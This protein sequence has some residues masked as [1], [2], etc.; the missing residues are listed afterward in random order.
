M[1]PSALF[2]FTSVTR[3]IDK[4]V[5][6]GDRTWKKHW[7]ISAAPS[8]PE[9]FAS[10]PITYERAFG[11]PGDSRNPVG[12]GPKTAAVARFEVAAQSMFE[13]LGSLTQRVR[14]S[15]NMW[16]GRASVKIEKHTGCEP[17]E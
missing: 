10:M 14:D 15:F 8:V 13:S 1:G 17:G 3:S 6:I 16:A 5:V 12:C 7:V 2:S 4:T 9:K 11:G